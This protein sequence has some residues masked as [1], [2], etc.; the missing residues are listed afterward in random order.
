MIWVSGTVER[1]RRLCV[2]YA[3]SIT[4]Y[5]RVIDAGALCAR[6][7]ACGEGSSGYVQNVL[8]PKELVEL[9]YSLYMSKYLL[10]TLWPIYGLVEVA[11]G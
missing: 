3:E 6:G 7:V 1:V 4:P 2:G 8:R 10:V 11:G 5:R 9:V